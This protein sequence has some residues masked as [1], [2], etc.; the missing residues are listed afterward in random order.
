[1]S[2]HNSQTSIAVGIGVS[3]RFQGAAVAMVQRTCCNEAPNMSEQSYVRSPPWAMYLFHEI[4]NQTRHPQFM[5][6]VSL[7]KGL[8]HNGMH[9]CSSRGSL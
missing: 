9:G 6:L 7:H 1:M 8:L 3:P 4:T 2:W 5:M